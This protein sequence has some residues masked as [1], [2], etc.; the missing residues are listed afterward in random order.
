[1]KQYKLIIFESNISDNIMSKNAKFYPQKYTKEQREKSFLKHR[2]ELGKKYN[3]DGKK[4]LHPKQKDVDY[5]VDYQDGTFIK[6]KEKH[7]Q[8]EDFW[9]EKLPADILIISKDYPNITIGH[10]MADCPILIA[11]DTKKQIAA[12][13]HDGVL[14]I[15][16]EVPRLT[17]EALKQVAGST[18]E[19]IKVYIGSCVKKDSYQYDSYPKW[20][21]NDVWKDCIIKKENTYYIDM[22]KAIKKQLNKEEISNIIESP[23]DT[24][25]DPNY[26]SHIAAVKGNN[27]KKGQNFVG[28]FY[29]EVK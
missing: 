18:P 28:C 8:K 29:Q 2:I 12:V 21:T 26:Y 4:I 11:E 13:S 22:V 27:K 5:D 17:I 15:N 25:Q 20:A 9:D 1:M 3:I 10:Q 16:R 14:Q 6:I 19:D 23:I 24:Y 7:L